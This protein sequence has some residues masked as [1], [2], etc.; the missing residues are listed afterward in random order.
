MWRGLET[1]SSDYRAS[2]RPDD[3]FSEPNRDKVIRRYNLFFAFEVGDLV[4]MVPKVSY[5]LHSPNARSNFCWFELVV[6]VGGGHC[7]EII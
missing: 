6:G 5:P 1:E 2:H 4:A 3:L 7:K